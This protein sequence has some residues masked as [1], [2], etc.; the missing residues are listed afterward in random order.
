MPGSQVSS[1]SFAHKIDQILRYAALANALD[2]IKRIKC[3]EL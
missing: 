3:T 2:P 1:K